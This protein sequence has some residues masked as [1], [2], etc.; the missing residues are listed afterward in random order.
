[1]SAELRPLHCP[2]C[3]HGLRSYGS[4]RRHMDE[5]RPPHRRD[6]ESTATNI[7]VLFSAPR[8][9]LVCSSLLSADPRCHIALVL[10]IL[11]SEIMFGT[12]SATPG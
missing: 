11:M 5:Q 12:R 10:R 1:M 7:A 4:L 9:L 2:V 3:R 6:G 8:P